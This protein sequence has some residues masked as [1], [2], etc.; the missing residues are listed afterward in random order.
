[1]GLLLVLPGTAPA[2]SERTA[3][4]PAAYTA[5]LT[6]VH[7]VPDLHAALHSATYDAAL[8][9]DDLEWAAPI[10][11]VHQIAARMPALPLVLLG[12]HGDPTL[13]AAAGRAGVYYLPAAE[14][15]RL[16][17]VLANARAERR[18][19]RAER[20][21]A[22]AELRR[23]EE[24]LRMILTNMPVM[25]DA[26][27]DDDRIVVWNH[28]CERVTGYSA[29][30]MIGRR[31]YMALLYPD[32]VQRQQ[33][34][35]D[36]HERGRS[37]RDWE[38]TLTSKDGTQ[39]IVL[40]SNIAAEFPV[41]GWRTW[42]VGV[43]ITA[44]REA[45][46][47][48]LLFERNLLET[49]KLESLGSLAG[50]IAHD[51]NNL[52]AVISG[53]VELLLLDT[54]L[55]SPGVP[56]LAKIEQTA[57]RAT[58]LLKQLLVYAGRSSAAVIPLQLNELIRELAELLQTTA[59]ASVALELQLAPHLPEV[60]GDVTQLR[61]LLMNLVTN[62]AEALA[63]EARPR[64][65]NAPHGDAGI[66][67]GRITIT[68]TARTMERAELDTALLGADLAPGHYVLLAVT[69]TGVGMS[70][71]TQARIFDPFFSTKFTGRGLG[72][73][74]VLGIVRAHHGA[75]DVQSAP[76]HGSTF[77]I[78]LPPSASPS[79]APPPP[80]T[81]DWRA[82]GTLLVIDDEPGVAE[83][84]ATIARRLGFEVL[85]APGGEQ[86]LALLHAHAA[87]VVC[88]L[89]DLTMPYMSGMQVFAQIRQ[90]WPALPV[91]LTSGY[92]TEEYEQ[93]VAA[94][95]VAFLKKPFAVADLRAMLRKATEG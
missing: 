51:F 77:T 55:D 81:G 52:L 84:A 69:D 72:L 7:T 50:G 19:E 59:G 1:M 63:S 5:R 71:T 31:D 10:S 56:L 93:A 12:Y 95:N 24:M 15:E 13:A 25:L 83:L 67:K 2:R 78:I 90:H 16:G 34:I 45:E 38:L 22:E 30:E 75:L 80:A 26:M 17:E 46:Q 61:Q 37:C 62:A 82:H 68:T 39:K 48:R 42:G 43:D 18:Y 33:I 88:V 44:Q 36:W 35:A 4:L 66:R 40:W 32:P 92:N 21:Q 91:I 74:A 85:V 64:S 27:D 60:E 58:E 73:A 11:A 49:Q 20:Q 53:N 9:A 87:E 8:I 23:S 6:T 70:E 28:E 47:A 86:G 29:A 54:P 14:F 3:A 79:A 94:K 76:G 65:P 57:R 89:L 41:P